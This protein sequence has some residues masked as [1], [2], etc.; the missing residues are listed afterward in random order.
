MLRQISRAWKGKPLKHCRILLV[1]DSPDILLV[2]GWALEGRGYEVVKASGGAEA[3]ERMTVQDYDLVISDL[4][5]DPVDGL[6]LLK[7]VKARNPKTKVIIFTAHDDLFAS[8]DARG[9][10][11]DAYLLKQSGLSEILERIS[12]HLRGSECEPCAAGA[13]S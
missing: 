13:S 12:D 8:I 1:D 11:A 5:M 7:E 9:L 2:F 10:G 3:I 4:M 6:A